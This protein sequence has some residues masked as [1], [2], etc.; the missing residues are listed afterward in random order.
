MTDEWIIH[1]KTYI[2]RLMSYRRDAQWMPLALVSTSSPSEGHSHPVS[3]EAINP[4]PTKDE[5]D[6]IAKKLAIQW[7]DSQLPSVE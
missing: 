3:N 6:V 7:I 4:L 1:Y 2:I 5:A